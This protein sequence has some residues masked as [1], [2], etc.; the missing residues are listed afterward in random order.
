MAHTITWQRGDG[1]TFYQPATGDERMWEKP[2]WDTFWS[3]D[4]TYDPADFGDNDHQGEPMLYRSQ[5]WA[6]WIARRHEKRRAK[7]TLTEI[8]EVKGS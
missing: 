4:G 2:N 1:K 8:H 3:V 5:R 6:M 7:Q